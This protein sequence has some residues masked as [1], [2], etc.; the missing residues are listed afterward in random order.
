MSAEAFIALAVFLA[1]VIVAARWIDDW[2]ERRQRS[3][4][5]YIERKGRD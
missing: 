5:D 3:H 2:M 4:D 1:A